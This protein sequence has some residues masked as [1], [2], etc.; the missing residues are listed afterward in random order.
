MNKIDNPIV[1]IASG[2]GGVGKT[3]F[4]ITLAHTLAKSGR[5][6][7]LFDGDIGL[8]NIDVQLGLTVGKDISLV[9]R[10]GAHIKDVIFP[11][12]EGNFDIVAGRSGS[13]SLAM[14][15]SDVLERLTDQLYSLRKQYDVILLDLGAGVEQHV[16]TLANSAAHVVVV[17]TDEPTSLT[18]AYAFIKLTLQTKPDTKFSIVVNQAATQKEGEATWQALERACSNFLQ[19][20]PPLLGVVR[21]DNKVKEAIR[22][23]SPLISK[24]P[25]TTSAT[26]VAA[27]SAK[28]LQRMMS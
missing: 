4:S 11:Y 9:V 10:S 27:I 12:E 19:Q 23:Q 16:R 28:L 5:Q 14:L 3:W 20:S 2:K 22:A 13:A 8:A 7:L 15:S 1:A 17:I 18:D 24:S 21:R 26:D 6:V 25:R